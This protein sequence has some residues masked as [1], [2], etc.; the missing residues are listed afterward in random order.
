MPDSPDAD[1]VTASGL[2]LPAGALAWRFSRSSGPG[3]QH[4]NTSDTR[5]E[6]VAD[7]SRLQGPDEVV[8]RVRRAHGTLRVVAAGERSQW[9]NRLE[10]RRRLEQRIERAAAAPRRRRRTVPSPGSVERRLQSKREQS[11][12]KSSRRPPLDD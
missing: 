2:R 10:A 7:M 5:V 6:V 9:L 12:K 1:L 8:E 4:V 11:E 3:G